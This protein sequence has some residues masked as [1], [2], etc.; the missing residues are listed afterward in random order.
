MEYSADLAARGGLKRLT[1]VTDLSL[2]G[3]LDRGN[4]PTEESAI[5][6]TEIY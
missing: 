6:S 3:W 5:R 2:S 4:N 1:S